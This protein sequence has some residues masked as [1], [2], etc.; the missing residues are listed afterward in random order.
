MTQEQEKD[1]AKSMRTAMGGTEV[2][3]E[4]DGQRFPV[5]LFAQAAPKICQA[6]LARLPVNGWLEHARWSGPMCIWNDIDLDQGGVPIENPVAFVAP[7]DIVY[8][9]E[10]KDIGIAFGVTQFR[11]QTGAVYVSHIGRF[12]G[13]LARLIALGENLQKSGEKGILLSL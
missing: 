7:G 5:E 13:D 11:E 6:L 12:T 2:F 9:Q 8:H 4:L 10:H 3:A 1:P